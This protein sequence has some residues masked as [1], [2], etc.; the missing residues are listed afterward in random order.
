[1]EKEMEKGIVNIIITE[2]D[3]C[4]TVESETIFHEI[5][6]TAKIPIRAPGIYDP[7]NKNHS[8][9]AIPILRYMTSFK[10]LQ[11]STV[12]KIEKE[13]GDIV[14]RGIFVILEIQGQTVLVEKETGELTWS[15][16]F[17]GNQSKRLQKEYIKIL[18]DIYLYIHDNHGRL[19]NDIFVLFNCIGV[20][21]IDRMMIYRINRSRYRSYGSLTERDG[22]IDEL[23]ANHIYPVVS[24]ICADDVSLKY[25]RKLD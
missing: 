3:S 8:T 13:L 10:R 14:Q 1:M 21:E 12:A 15:E 6:T 24:Y 7:T 2:H 22:C 20:N 16:Y 17:F 4:L 23:Y 19:E 5:C 11:S 25:P 9:I 18:S